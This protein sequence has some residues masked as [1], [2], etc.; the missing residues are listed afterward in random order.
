[1][2]DGRT[3]KVVEHI[4]KGGHHKRVGSIIAEPTTA[5]RPVAL[6]RIDEQRDESTIDQ[7][8]R[9]LGAL[10]HRTAHDGGRGGAEHCLKDQKALYRQVTLVEREVAPVGSAYKTSTLAAK[11]K[12]KAKEEEQERAE[13]KID[14]VLHQ[15]VGR[16]LTTCE[17]CL[18]QGK[19]WL[20]P[21]N[22]HGCQ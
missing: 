10:C 9:E 3:R 22:Q 11:H 8:H 14:K 13:H 21:E 19:T 6:Y 7:I 12:A 2:H 5:P 20:H 17:T 16:V 18:T 1:M 4:S 15:D